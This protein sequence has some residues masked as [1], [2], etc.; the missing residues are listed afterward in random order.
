[1]GILGDILGKLAGGTSQNAVV[2][3]VGNLLQNKEIGG[4]DGLVQK[5]TKGGLGDIVSSWVSTGANLPV[6]ADQI[7]KGLGA[8]QVAQMASQLGI[9]PEAMGKQ[10]AKILPGVV[11]KLTPEG[12]V[13]SQDLLSQGLSALL[14]GK[15]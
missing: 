11:D 8:T 10:L 13:P 4:L 3:A 5:F 1:M 12:K 6:S 2:D 14:K 15:L 9:T 7:Q